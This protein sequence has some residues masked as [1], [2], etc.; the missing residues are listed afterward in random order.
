MSAAPTASESAS[1]KPK[2]FGDK[3]FDALSIVKSVLLHVVVIGV[4]FVGYENSSKATYKTPMPKHV[5]AVIV[6][7]PKPKPVVKKKPKKKPKPKA[8]PK[9]KPKPKKKAVK[10]A[11]PK[12]PVAKAPKPKPKPKPKPIF[13]SSEMELMMEEE[14]TAMEQIELE[15]A[16]KERLALAAR[17]AQRQKELSIVDEYSVYIREKVTRHWSRPPS[18]RNGMQVELQI[19]MI[20]GGDVMEVRVV[21]SSGNDAF[22]RSAEMAVRTAGRF[23]VPSD[24]AVFNAYFRTLKLLFKPEDLP[25]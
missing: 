15:L 14:D 19:F 5:Q 18:A 6:E 7:K 10:K 3:K 1:S 21:E 8:K 12:K 24:P 25:L 22:D 2:S 16:E 4:F 23:E 9:P 13:D 11:E 17:E 20:P